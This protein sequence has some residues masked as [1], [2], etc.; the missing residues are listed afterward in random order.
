MVY[1]FTKLSEWDF[2]ACRFFGSGLGNLLF[3]WARAIV[4][5]KRD[6]LVEIWPTWR[7]V[8]H[9]DGLRDLLKGAFGLH[10][11]RG[12]RNYNRLFAPTGEQ[13]SGY[14]KLSLM[15]TRKRV[16]EEDY[17]PE[18]LATIEGS[19]V[20]FQGERKRFADILTHHSLLRTELLRRCRLDLREVKSF[21]FSGS[22]SIHVRLGD[23]RWVGPSEE[24]RKWGA[25]VRL[26][27]SWYVEKIAQLRSRLGAAAPVHVFSDGKDRELAEILTLPNCRRLGFGSALADLFAMA[28]ANVLISSASSL[29]RWAA[30]LG[31]PP[32]IHFRGTL[33]APLYYDQPASEVESDPGEELPEAFLQAVAAAA[34]RPRALEPVV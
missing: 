15:M 23:F 30:F 12:L 22:I 28:R 31:R 26:P 2:G 10:G 17:S 32:V 14:R 20:I 3:P 11:M 13:I 1:C 8:F 9:S 25:N 18:R 6:G 21:D 33:P 34:S 24:I 7:Q 27:L 16:S 19:I 29:N 5:A 4:A